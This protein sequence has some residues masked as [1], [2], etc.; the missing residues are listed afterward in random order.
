MKVR[1]IANAGGGTLRTSGE[2]GE[3]AIRDALREAGV[4]ADL[5]LCQPEDIADQFRDAASAEGVDAV[6][7]GG[8]DGTISCAVGHLA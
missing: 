5:R 1:V 2:G 7:A 4:D 3:E 8:G 6:V